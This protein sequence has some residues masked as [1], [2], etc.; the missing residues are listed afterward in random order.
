[1]SHKHMLLSKLF[2]FLHC[3]Q[4]AMLVHSW[5]TSTEGAR[6]AAVRKVPGTSSFCSKFYC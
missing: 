2:I 4:A 5:L 1:M 3:L 6:A